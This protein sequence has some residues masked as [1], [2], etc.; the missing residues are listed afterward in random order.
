[1]IHQKEF[2]S[3]MQETKTDDDGNESFK[4]HKAEVMLMMGPSPL[5]TI[6]AAAQE[7]LK[8]NNAEEYDVKTRKTS[9]VNPSN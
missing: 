4:Y 3:L 1:L 8:N 2:S 7:A 9:Q 6:S 5:Q